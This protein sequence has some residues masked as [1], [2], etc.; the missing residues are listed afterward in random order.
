MVELPVNV[1]P[2]MVRLPPP[3][4]IPPPPK[5]PAP[6]A[7]LFETMQFVTKVALSIE[8]EMMPPP[9]TA[10]V[11]RPPVTVTPEIVKL[12]LASRNGFTSS[13]RSFGCVC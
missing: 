10:V 12:K 11:S 13:T 6:V 4:E 5:V 3:L 1:V 7:E 9:P 8:P 2:E